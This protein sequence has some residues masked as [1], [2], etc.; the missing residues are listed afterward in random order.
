MNLNKE[1]MKKI[2]L[3][4]TFA[5][6]L[7]WLINNVAV[8]VGILSQIISLIMPFLI[9]AALAFVLN[10]PLRAIEK[11]VCALSEKKGFGF[12]K[13]QSRAVSL[14]LTFVLVIAVIV[15][16]F[17]LIIPELGRTALTFAATVQPAMDNLQ[18]E[19]LN[20]AKNYPDLEQQIRSIDINWSTVSQN[21]VS[22]LSVGAGSI[23]KSTVNVATTVVNVVTNLVIA[24][25]FAVYVLVQKETLSRQAKKLLYAGL[26][27]DK[28]DVVLKVTRLANR[29]FSNFVTGQ[30]LEACIL[31]CMFFIAMSIFDFPYAMVISLVIVVSALI[32]IVG[33]FIGCVF[34]VILIV[35]ISPMKAFWFIVLFLILQQIEGNVIYPRV[36]GNSVG[37]PAIWVLV[38]ITVGG[39]MMGILGMI[40]FIPICSVV[41]TLLK[42]AVNHR[43]EQR[44]IKIDQV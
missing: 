40:L 37:L 4:I 15:M 13:K 1:N 5:I 7:Y 18:N 29:T 33:A 34:G 20:L 23:V 42:E 26:K 35:M 41:Y 24:I 8:F 19:L 28:A 44:K 32:P 30:F 12:I 3:L 9:G 14:L 25:I 36:V 43:I 16:V 22:F 31:G 38:A 27:K 2:A 39:N 10:A 21:V 11:K 17:F 6:V